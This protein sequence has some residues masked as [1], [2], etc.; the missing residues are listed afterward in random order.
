MLTERNIS[1]LILC[2]IALVG[3]VSADGEAQH[4]HGVIELGIV[5]EGGT[6]A[7]SLTA[8]LSDV[9]GFEHAPESDEQVQRIESAADLLSNADKMFGLA[10]SADCGVP[11]ISVDGPGY[12]SGETEH[13]HDHQ[14]GDDHHHSD[15]THSHES[16]HEEHTEIVANYEWTCGDIANLDALELNFIDGFASVEKVE[17][18]V[19]TSSGARVFTFDGQEASISLA[20]D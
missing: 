10:D 19:L 4:V 18:Q 1:R 9:V 6:I 7:V 17:I 3:L 15:H 20:A 13:S 12:F 16:N 8:P 2:A 14:H 11:D 5:V